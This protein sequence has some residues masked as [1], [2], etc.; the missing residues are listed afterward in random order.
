MGLSITH[1]IILLVIVLLIFGP[2]NLPKLGQS[3]GEAIKGFKKGLN[4]NEIDVTSTRDRIRDADNANRAS[5][6]VDEK[7]KV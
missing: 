3:L 6:K 7:D 5:Q 4:D 1:I 2:K